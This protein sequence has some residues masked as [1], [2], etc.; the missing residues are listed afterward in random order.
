M[1][2]YYNPVR[3]FTAGLLAVEATY[4]TQ[5]FFEFETWILGVG[6][7]VI[8]VLIK[9]HKDNNEGMVPNW[10]FP[11]DTFSASILGSMVNF[12]LAFFFAE[13]YGRY[14]D[15]YAGC[16]E[17]D[18]T[19]KNF[20][21]E[22]ITHLYPPKFREHVKVAAKYI[23]ASI[24]LHYFTLAGPGGT[25]EDEEYDE[26]RKRGLLTDDEIRYLKRCGRRHRTILQSWAERVVWDAV[27][28]VQPDYFAAPE[29]AS[30]VNRIALTTRGMEGAYRKV[31]NI[32]AM[33]VPFSYFHLMNCAITFNLILLSWALNSIFAYSDQA[34]TS[35]I[36]PYWIFMSLLLGLRCV[37][38]H[39][40]DPFRE[41]RKDRLQASL[42]V[43]AFI[44]TG[45]DEI[46]MLLE[47]MTGPDP[48]QDR[49]YKKYSEEGSK[50]RVEQSVLLKDGKFAPVNT[51]EKTNK[52][53]GNTCSK[54]LYDVKHCHRKA[55]IGPEETHV[56]FRWNS[57]SHEGDALFP[58]FQELRANQQD[59]SEASAST[60]P[61]T[62]DV[63]ASPEQPS[64]STTGSRAQDLSG[65]KESGS[66]DVWQA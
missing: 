22:M 63:E 33:P 13:C 7:I 62:L 2:Y 21:K 54:L 18:E 58:F 32:L 46:L 19:A 65:V 16:M 40:A 4:F 45:H 55:F 17:I 5:L 56:S 43:D 14:K 38:A 12:L 35:T 49:V 27:H 29:R 52:D 60:V 25:I 26:V 64:T 61:T 24:F 31:D 50:S 1:V 20:I 44:N 34:Y 10:F 57:V 36:L 39:L 8:A 53:P 41:E 23:I 47:T 11:M 30:F 48:V 37:A 15:V 66:L 28:N 9:E 42:P 3:G 51:G 6:H 59:G